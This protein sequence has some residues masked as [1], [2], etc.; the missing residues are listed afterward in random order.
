MM[1]VAMGF[2]QLFAE[3]GFGNA[4]IHFQDTTARQMS[5]LF[6]ANLLVAGF[7]CVMFTVG[8]PLFVWLFEEARLQELTVLAALAVLVSSLGQLYQA[9]LQ[10]SLKFK[11]LALSEVVAAAVGACVA[12]ASAAMGQGVFAL[13]YGYLSGAFVRT[14]GYILFGVRDWRPSLHF[15]VTDLR[16]Y[17]RFCLYQIGER[18]I[19]LLAQRTDQLII[20]TIL[21]AGALGYYSLAYNLVI[22]PVQRINPMVTRVAFPVFSRVQNE[23]EKLT[24]GFFTVQ[25]ILSRINFPIL[26]GIAVTAPVFTPLLFGLQ[27]APSVVPIQV[28]AVV[29]L[30]RSTGNPVGALLLAR[31]RAGLAFYWNLMAVA[32]QLPAVYAGAQLGG[33]VGVCIALLV[34]QALFFLGNY[35][36]LLRALL[37]PCLRIHIA[38]LF[39]ATLTTTI[40]AF[41]VF[42]VTQSFQEATYLAL[43]IQIVSGVAVYA[44]ANWALYRQEWLDLLNLIRGNDA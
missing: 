12:I 8:A 37:G 40:M 38:S 43:S 10:K 9:L 26:M 42:G 3:A 29:A 31:G 13:L 41:I 14:G 39:P 34:T 17:L 27:W 44:L 20:G 11:E 23:I 32:I 30:I 33:V 25:Q 19:N 18:F 6:W 15:R 5:S 1:L 16:K 24:K 22:F 35:L 7:V 21:G 28:L 4:I 2:A 36:V